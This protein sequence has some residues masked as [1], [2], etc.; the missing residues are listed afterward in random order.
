LK[1]KTFWMVLGN[2]TPTVKHDTRADALAE[3]TRLA[4]RIEGSEFHILES[5]G[6][7][8]KRSTVFEP[9]EIDPVNDDHG[10]PF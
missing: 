8:V 3:A 4:L 7:V 9:H 6:T 2:G 10:P 1:R 5:I